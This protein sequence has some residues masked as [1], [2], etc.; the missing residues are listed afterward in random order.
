LT[1]APPHA[2]RYAR[3]GHT[4]P[5]R[6]RTLLGGTLLVLTLVPGGGHALAQT[7]PGQ[8]GQQVQSATFT[9]PSLLQVIQ[10]A[11]GASR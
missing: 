8:A 6:L 10:A 5:A 4:V 7:P 3:V 1:P 2:V 9:G 11:G